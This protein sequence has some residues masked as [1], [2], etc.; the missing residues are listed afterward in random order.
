M[1][2]MADVRLTT[3]ECWWYYWLTMN[4]LSIK[5]NQAHYLHE[6]TINQL[7]TSSES[8]LNQLLSSTIRLS[9]WICFYVW[10]IQNY[11]ST[12]HQLLNSHLFSPAIHHLFS[13]AKKT[14]YCPQLVLLMENQPLNQQKKTINSSCWS[15]ACLPDMT[16]DVVSLRPLCLGV[17]SAIADSAARRLGWTWPGNYNNWS[18]KWLIDGWLTKIY[19]WGGWNHQSVIDGK[20]WWMAN[21]W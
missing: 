19:H 13:P 5:I 10:I 4:Q 18:W 11:E 2:V 21:R 12:V 7:L 15:K 14:S 8:T 20:W 17:I 16:Q 3:G 9:L 6:S 1:N